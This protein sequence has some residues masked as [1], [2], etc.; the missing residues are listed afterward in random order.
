MKYFI[1]VGAVAIGL[2]TFAPDSDAHGGGGGGGGGHGG[3]GGGH[4]GGGG[5]MFHGGGGRGGGAMF[6]GG[7]AMFHGGWHSGGFRGRGRFFNH[8]RFFGPGFGFYGDGYPWWDDWDYGY[9]PG[10]YYGDYGDY[11]YQYYGDYEYYG[12]PSNGVQNPQVLSTR[13]V[14]T[15]LAWRGYYR[16]RIDGAM[17]PET[18]EAIRSFQAHQSLPVTGQID[19]G[20]LNALRRGGSNDHKTT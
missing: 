12:G 4:G 19:N 16:G 3:G 9:Y 6:R 14:Q 1:L 8:G 15:A 13:A 18:R 20:L 10:P 2:L 11:P 17:G 5:G 7:S